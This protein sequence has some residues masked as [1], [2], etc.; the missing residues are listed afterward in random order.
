MYKCVIDPLKSVIVDRKALLSS[1]EYVTAYV[2]MD[3]WHE[4]IIVKLD[5]TI[6][7]VGKNKK[8]M[9]LS[10]RVIEDGT[11]KQIFYEEIYTKY[12]HRRKFTDWKRAIWGSRDYSP[13]A[14]RAIKDLITFVEAR[15]TFGGRD[16]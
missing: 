12:Y 2:L 1:G 16:A 6:Y 15:Y 5:G 9:Y 13:E 11:L 4:A 7:A 8:K 14:A 3:G 10:K